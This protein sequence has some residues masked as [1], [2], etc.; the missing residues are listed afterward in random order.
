ML[1]HSMGMKNH[2]MYRAVTVMML[3]ENI[4]FIRCLYA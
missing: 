3:I 2:A 4:R 1:S